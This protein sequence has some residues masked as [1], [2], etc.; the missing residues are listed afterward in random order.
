[1]TSRVPGAGVVAAVRTV[2]VELP[3]GLVMLAILIVEDEPGD[4]NQPC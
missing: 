3:L 2:D 1:M 4:A